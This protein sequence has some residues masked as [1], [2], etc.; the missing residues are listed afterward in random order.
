MSPLDVDVFIIRNDRGNSI[1]S[2]FFIG[3]DCCYAYLQCTDRACLI[4]F[5]MN[6]LKC[7]HVTDFHR[8]SCVFLM[9]QVRKARYMMCNGLQMA[10]SFL[11][12]TAVSICNYYYSNNPYEH[13]SR[14][15]KLCYFTLTWL[16]FVKRSR[17]W[18]FGICVIVFLPTMLTSISGEGLILASI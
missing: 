15:K 16:D 18:C 8:L 4:D 13:I 11:W 1:S 14:R 12:F 3:V 2:N 17:Y 10:K 7:R 5:L 9:Y 6:A